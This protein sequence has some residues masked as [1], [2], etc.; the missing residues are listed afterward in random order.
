MQKGFAIPAN[1]SGGSEG[2]NGP[3]HEMRDVEEGKSQ[4]KGSHGDI[5]QQPQGSNKRLII[6]TELPPPI[7]VDE[8]KRAVAEKLASFNQG[9]CIDVRKPPNGRTFGV[10]IELD[11]C[12]SAQYLMEKGL[13][14]SGRQVRLLISCSTFLSR[15]HVPLHICSR[16]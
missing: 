15:K 16:P 11:T 14:L 12:Q 10:I 5:Q 6:L 8:V 9:Q 2:N 1:P 4:G 7:S 3:R 13:L